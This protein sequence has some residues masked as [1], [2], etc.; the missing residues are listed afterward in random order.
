MRLIVGLGNPGRRYRRTRH[1]TGWE[2]LEALASAHGISI[3]TEDGWAQ[4]GR[5][6]IGG[7]RVILA[8]PETYVNVSGTAV[9][10]LRRRHR[11][12]VEHLMV[13]VDDLDLPIGAVRVREKGSHGGH[14]GLRSIVEALGTTAFARLRVGIGRPPSNEDPAEYVL[15]RPSAHERVLLDEAVA[16]AAEGVALWVTD[17]VAAAMNRCNPRRSADGVGQGAVGQAAAKESEG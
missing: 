2:V 15:Q 1:N 3:A 17:G 12:P 10:D 13:I 11:V 8:R 9:A 4:V 5:G 16:R 14:N 6:T 7:R